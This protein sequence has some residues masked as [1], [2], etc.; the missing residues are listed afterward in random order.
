MKIKYYLLAAAA[1]LAVAACDTE[2]D[3]PEQ[4]NQANGNY[5]SIHGLV[6]KGIKSIGSDY[7]TE[8]YD[9]NGRLTSYSS[10]DGGSATYT[11]N[12]DGYPATIVTKE[13]YDG[14]LY[15]TRQTFE[16]K[17]GSKFCPYPMGPGNIFHIFENGLAQGLSKVTW[18][19][20][21]YGTTVME[22]KF[23]GDKLTV[24]TSGG[25][26]TMIDSLGREVPL[27]YDDLVIEYKGD[28][29]YRFSQEHEFIGPLTYQANGMFDTYVEGF[30]SWNPMYAG[31]VTMERT[32]T[33]NKNFKDRMLIDRE[34]SKYYNEG[35]SDPYDIETI[36]Y[37]YNEHGD[38]IREEVTHTA[39]HAD[40]I[41]MN[42]E[43][44]YDDKGNWIKMTANIQNLNYPD[45]NNTWSSE[46]Q[47]VYY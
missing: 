8:N 12:S 25:N 21:E 31:V 32:R 30:Y 13:S 5:W 41:I 9:S 40:H 34:V 26:R 39:E 37:N 36:V 22:Y 2:T 16:Y 45:Y 17:N 14:V 15:T 23:D 47:I 46:R 7:Y 6:P 28:Y 44:V 10:Q 27:V 38:E 11:Y 29:P 35:E 18:N 1:I 33:V 19:S 43:Y 20:E 3:A 4:E 42:Y 24:S